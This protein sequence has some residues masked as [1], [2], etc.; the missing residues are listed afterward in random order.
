MSD[1]ITQEMVDKLLT[2]TELLI[3]HIYWF[4]QDL[5]IQPSKEHIGAAINYTDIQERKDDF[6]NELVNTVASW[7]Y[8]KA[9]SKQIVD[10]RL[11]IV[12]FDHGNASSFLT[13]QAFSKFRP[14][15]P[16]GQFGELL[17]FNFIQHFFMAVPLLRKQRITTSLGHERYGAD[18]IHF[19]KDGNK[20]ILII[21]ESK[22]YKSKYKF[23]EAFKISLESI[24]NSFNNFSGELKLYTYDDFIE[25]ELEN[26]AKKYKANTLPDVHFELVC[27]IAYNENKVLTGDNEKDIKQSITSIIEERCLGLDDSCFNTIDGKI[28]DR[29][30]YVI[31]P[32]WDLDKLLIEFQTL[33]G[34]K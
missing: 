18:A 9:K 5:N 20:N 1:E 6:L 4:K 34:T 10:D 11:A 3:N 27:L 31:F 14:G 28:I 26:I 29:I 21:G 15:Q 22:C 25:T 8:S 2:H 16:Q 23:N 17:L 24:I 19:K 12:N 33:V 7:V 30:N 32:I 13:T